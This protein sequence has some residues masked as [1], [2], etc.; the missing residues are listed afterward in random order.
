MFSFFP[1][2]GLHLQGIINIVYL[3]TVIFIATLIVL[4]N[5]SPIKTISWILVLILLPFAGIIIYLFFGQEYRKKKMF[6]RKGLHDLEKLRKLTQSQLDQLPKNYLALS[7]A[8][9]QK[10]RLMNLLLANS[11]AIL[12]DD[13]EIKILRNG[14]QVYPAMFQAMEEARHHIHLEFYI[15]DNDVVGNQLRELLIRKAG[16]GVE[17]RFI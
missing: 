12:S 15:V 10:R 7:N 5:R 1:E 16:A 6:S 9:Y 14:E 17:V 3:L 13:N 11:N 8:I 4:E 2:L